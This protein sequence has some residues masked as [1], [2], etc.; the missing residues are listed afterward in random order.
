MGVALVLFLSMLD[1]LI[2]ASDGCHVRYGRRSCHHDSVTGVVASCDGKGVEDTVP[3][4]L[5][6]DVV[7]LSLSNFK[8]RRLQF[9]NFSK[10]ASIQCLSLKHSTEL[11]EIDPNTFSDLTQLKELKLEGT[12]L[13]VNQ[14]G[15]LT[16]PAPGTAYRLIALSGTPSLQGAGNQLISDGSGQSPNPLE[17]L[18]TLN[19][20]G[21]H[22]TR[23][24]NSAL[25]GQLKSLEELDLSSNHLASLEWLHFAD[26]T[27]LVH[28]S[29]RNNRF[30]TIPEQVIGL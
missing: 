15:F 1:Q 24:G 2:S 11:R 10:F 29:L 16:R 28:L 7:Y 26:L 27:K 8:F 3:Q 9:G 12:R 18:L 17:S 13:D 20:H 25:F 19:F 5:P 6:N 22:L 30:Q 4:N 14:L 23:F 21:N